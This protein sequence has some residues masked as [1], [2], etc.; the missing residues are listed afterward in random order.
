MVEQAVKG[1]LS[2][3]DLQKRFSPLTSTSYAADLRQFFAWSDA[4]LAGYTLQTITFRQIRSFIASLMDEG[5]SPVS[6]NRKL[7]A[8]KSFFGYLHREGIVAANP[9]SRVQGPK[10]PKKLPEFIDVQKLGSLF[11]APLREL[12]FEERRNRLMLEVLYQ[13]GIRRAELIGL[14]EKDVDLYSSQLRVFGKRAKERI[15][16]FS[17]RLT[18][19]LKKYLREKKEKGLTDER[20]FVTAKNKPLSPQQ[21]TGI[22]SELLSAATTNRKRSPHVLRHSFATHLLDNGADINAV[23]ELL[24]HANLSATQVYTHNSIE[25]LKRSYKQAHPRSGH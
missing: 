17:E 9:A 5:L 23:K 11:E 25:K 24:G 15:V 13:T 10:I 4:E 19:E 12:S 7:S 3:L 21:V 14:C 1:F 2:Y 20:L 6:A 8:L 18:A 16:P 22:V